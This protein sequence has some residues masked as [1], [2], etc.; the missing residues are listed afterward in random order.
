MGVA[1]SEGINTRKYTPPS[2]QKSS[3]WM[4]DK[5]GHALPSPLLTECDIQKVLAHP[6]M[7]TR[8]DVG[9]I[10]R[11]TGLFSSARS[12]QDLVTRIMLRTKT[13]AILN[14]AGAS[15]LLARLRTTASALAPAGG[16]LAAPRAQ[17][18]VSVG[19]L[20]LVGDPRL[21]Y[22]VFSPQSEPSL[23]SQ[24]PLPAHAPPA[25]PRSP[26]TAPD[27]DRTLTLAKIPTLKRKRLRWFSTQLRVNLKNAKDGVRRESLKR[28]LEELGGSW[29]PPA[30]LTVPANVSG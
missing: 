25:L 3:E 22:V 28:K 6:D 29:T 30:G 8:G 9:G 21:P 19:P 11:M 16:L 24:P 26:L 10:L 15:R 1:G 27:D 12:L 2:M 20:P 17:P 4:A 13:D 7:V 5:L 23:P 14:S 18:D